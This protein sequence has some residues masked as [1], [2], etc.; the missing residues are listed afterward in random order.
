[1]FR[2][3]QAVG[4]SL[5]AVGRTAGLAE[6]CTAWL[7][8]VGAAGDKAAYAVTSAR[9][10]GQ[11]D[12]ASIMAGVD[13]PEAT[14]EFNAFA[15]LTGA[16]QADLVQAPIE[17]VEWASV[18]GTDLAVLRL[19]ST[20]GELADRGVRPIDPVAAVEQGAEILI[21]GVP[22]EGLA[23]DQ[24]YLRGSRCQVG[25]TSDILED[26]LLGRDGQASDCAGILDGSQGS[27]VFNPAGDAVAM[28]TT[29][30]I[31]STQATACALGL[32]CQVADDGGI[33]VKED[34]SYMLPVV[35]LAGC[36]P[37]GTFALGGDCALEDPEIGGAGPGGGVGRQAGVDGG[38]RA[39]GGAARGL[40]LDGCD[41]GEAG[42]VGDGG[43]HG[44][45][46]VA[47][48]HAGGCA[49]CRRCG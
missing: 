37:E 24:Q 40:H 11:T 35:A 16:G 33:S 4:T 19:G 14:V 27:P 39:R 12:P 21:A 46:G 31:G 26:G 38:H 10:V 18:R 34:T 42:R 22:V 2:Q 8:D 7:L 3:A 49:G 17:A 29:T 41:R 15:P 13:V 6:P 47:R 36:F 48:R 23:P 1:M 20:Y 30:T 28:V 45:R 9:C 32:P 43:L 5:T 44:A 25:E